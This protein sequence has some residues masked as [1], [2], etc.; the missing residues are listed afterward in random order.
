MIF[1]SYHGYILAV[2]L[3]KFIAAFLLNGNKIFYTVFGLHWFSLR[4]FLPALGLRVPGSMVGAVSLEERVS[5]SQQ[6]DHLNCLS[7]DLMLI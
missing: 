1:C 3:N 4:D 6:S 7:S 2:I 5:L